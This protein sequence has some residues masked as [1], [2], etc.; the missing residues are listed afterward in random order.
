MVDYVHNYGGDT[1]NQ[2]QGIRE[3][4]TAATTV[5]GSVKPLGQGREVVY[6]KLSTAAATA[7]LT[8]GNLMQAPAAVAL[9]MQRACAV[10][11]S[12]GAREVILSLGAASAV[13]DAYADGLLHISSGA[14]GGY[15]YMIQGHEAWAATNTA[16]KVILK[17]GLEVAL[18]TASI[19]NLIPNQYRN[20][21]KT[22][23][24]AAATAKPVG[25]M[26]I[27]AA[28]TNGGYVYL[29]K[30]GVW[31]ALINGTEITGKDVK[32]MSAEGTVGAV[33]T[34]DL[35]FARVGRCVV[36]GQ[37]TALVDFDL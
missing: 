28:F 18:T 27:S 24:S 37:A 10:T 29:G 4:K 16:A 8:P 30:K 7:A 17:D 25:V 14:G 5:L 31:P 32:V 3:I 15:S 34:A 35:T 21:I 23:A 2:V 11:A 22:L 19:C 9:H 20:V 13:A 6:A 36:T 26:L 12:I 33:G 1:R